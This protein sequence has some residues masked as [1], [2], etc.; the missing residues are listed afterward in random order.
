VV[1]VLLEFG[2]DIGR[3]R[4]RIV[5]ESDPN[6]TS[7]NKAGSEELASENESPGEDEQHSRDSSQQLIAP[8]AFGRDL[9]ALGKEGAFDPIISQSKEIDCAIQVLCRRTKNSPAL[10]G[11]VGIGKTAIVEGLA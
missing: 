3:W 2:D 7:L 5:E 8:R 6:F 9:P 11:E 10:I 4:P 1:N